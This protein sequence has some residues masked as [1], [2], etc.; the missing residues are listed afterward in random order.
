MFMDQLVFRCKM[1]EADVEEGKRSEPWWRNSIGEWQIELG[2]FSRSEVKRIINLLVANGVLNKKTKHE[3]NKYGRSVWFYPN[4][5][6]MEEIASEGAK[7][8]AGQN[9][10]LV[11]KTVLPS[12]NGKIKGSK[13]GVGSKKNLSQRMN[14]QKD[15]GP[16]R[17]SVGSK[18]NLSR[19]QIGPQAGPKRTTS[20]IPPSI[21]SSSIPIS[22]PN[23]LAPGACSP[24]KKSQG[25]QEIQRAPVSRPPISRSEPK[26]A[27]PVAKIVPFP[28][29]TS[30]EGAAVRARKAPK[31]VS[32]AVGKRHSAS[33]PFENLEAMSKEQLKV[34]LSRLARRINRGKHDSIKTFWKALV[35]LVYR[36]EEAFVPI[37]RTECKQ[38]PDLIAYCKEAGVSLTTFLVWCVEEW[39]SLND[40]LKWDAGLTRFPKYASILNLRSTL[41]ECYK[42]M[43]CEEREWL[44]EVKTLGHVFK[45]IR[46]VPG[47][48]QMRDEILDVLERGDCAFALEDECIPFSDLSEDQ[49]DELMRY[50]LEPEGRTHRG[51]GV[52]LEE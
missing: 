30:R 24:E 39:P 4:Y 26:E 27:G 7:M 32:A 36:D 15:S 40:H 9:K 28:S 11:E 49:R 22:T 34:L 48:H 12:D 20:S 13:T 2:G 35:A 33:L 46:D 10:D 17:T 38:T 1:A 52:R 44:V 16:R 51:E 45:R 19:G 18:K 21:P 37:T 29:G 5:K 6:R 42:S 47:D 41:V 43:R 8:L 50:S 25:L 14:K 31:A 23:R 3:K